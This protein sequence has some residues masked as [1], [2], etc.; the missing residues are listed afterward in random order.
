MHRNHLLEQV[1]EYRTRRPD[2]IE[3]VDRFLEFV[4]REKACFDRQTLEGHVTGSAW[5]ES[6]DGDSVLLLL[7]RKLGRWLQ[8]GGHADGDN[9][10][11][12]VARREAFE[13]TG[14]VH[15]LA[16]PKIFDLDIHQIPAR[17]SEPAHLHYDL[18]YRM[19]AATGQAAAISHESLDLKWYPMVDVAGWDGQPSISRMAIKSLRLR[20]KKSPP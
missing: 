11:L 19:S 3:T 2:E 16:D 10:V 15:L 5:V 9:D 6:A 12:N 13:E 1:E 18:R 4:R 8:P 7:H 20:P 17:G 14:L